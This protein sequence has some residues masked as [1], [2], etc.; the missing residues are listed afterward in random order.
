MKIETKFDTGQ[1]VWVIDWY[2]PQEHEP[3]WH[4]LNPSN[5]RKI[6]GGEI[7]IHGEGRISQSVSALVHFTGVI[8]K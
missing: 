5:R 4:L 3:H 2:Y 6:I 1:K 8:R 7:Y